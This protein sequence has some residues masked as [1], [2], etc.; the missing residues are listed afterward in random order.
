LLAGTVLLAGVLALVAWREQ[1]S[2]PRPASAPAAEFSAARAMDVLRDVVGDG[3]PRPV[4]SAANARGVE[5][6]VA[7]FRALGLATTVQETFAC[8]SFGSCARV[9]NVLAR[10]D[11]RGPGK[12]VLLVSHHDSVGAGPGA[13]DDAAGVAALLEIAR[14]LGSAPRLPRP[15]LFLATDGEEAGMVG[16]AAFAKQHPWAADVGAVVNVEARGTSG[17]SLMFET[18]GDDAWLAR[19]LRELPH[20]NTSSLFSAVYARMPNDTDLTVFKA[21]GVPGLNFAFIG[22]VGRYHTPFD[23]LAHV[24]PASLQDQGESV[25]AAVRALARSD[26]ERPPRGNAVFFHVLGLTVVSWPTAAALPAA[27]LALALVVAAL[28]I[29]ARRERLGARAVAAGLAAFVG[30]AVAAAGLGLA[31]RL[32]VFGSSATPSLFVSYRGAFVV[33]AWS[34]GV[35]G[36]AAAAGACARAGPVALWAGA[37]LGWSLLAVAASAALPAA[38]FPFVVP[39]AAYA[40]AG[41]PWALARSPRA[42]W[43]VAVLAPPVAAAVVLFQMAL[44]LHPALGPAA[45]PLVAALV[46]LVATALGP[47]VPSRP[48]TA[49]W[50]AAGIPAAALLGCGLGAAIA[51]RVSDAVPDRMAIGFHES[52]G[53]ARWL[54]ESVAKRVPEAARRALRFTSSRGPLFPWFPFRRGFAAPTAPAGLPAPRATVVEDQLRD[55]A[56]RVRARLASARGAPVLLFLVPPG[57][58]VLRATIDGAPVAPLHSRHRQLLDGW[59]PFGCATPAPEGIEL[60]LVVSGTAPFE[61]VLLDESPGLP[62]G[63]LAEALARAR[64]RDAVTSQDGDVTV[65][66]ARVPL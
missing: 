61:A 25:L 38:S 16:A 17:P 8:G 56:R 37:A 47:L 2:S 39:A 54:L 55:G 32:A 43:P 60:E 51:P 36:A 52:A 42:W 3:A 12:A 30:A 44:L 7:R 24:S 62:P 1:P 53:E 13:S 57:V 66:T 65:V 9:R 64:P 40:L 4:G 27:V 50:L 49:R 26:L 19:L 48:R 18:S 28:A 35:L 46:A 22:D 31:L 21:R 5:Q 23:D 11:G 45:A 58:Q 41:L 59:Q 29:A 14:A 6:I 10:L 34:A 20:P 33:A 63:A 15:V